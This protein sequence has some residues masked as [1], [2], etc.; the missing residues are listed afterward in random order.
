MADLKETARGLA[1]WGLVSRGALYVLV[2]VI[3]M[4]VSVGGGRRVRDR[5]GA[6]ATLTDTWRGKILVVALAFGLLG[7]A[8][9]RFFEAQAPGYRRTAIHWVVSAKRED[10]RRKRLATLIEDSRS[11]RRLRHLTRP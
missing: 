7:Y 6:L 10:T 5:G 11:G 8:A 4:D 1:R 2:G 9:W 3:A